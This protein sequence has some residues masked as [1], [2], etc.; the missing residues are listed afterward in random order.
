MRLQRL[1][2]HGALAPQLTP[3]YALPGW[4]DRSRTLV[5]LTVVKVLFL[6]LLASVTV[7]AGSITGVLLLIRRHRMRVSDAA[8]RRELEEIEREQRSFDHNI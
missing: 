5:S 6:I 3:Y 2:L 8:L 4:T 1:Q 7:L